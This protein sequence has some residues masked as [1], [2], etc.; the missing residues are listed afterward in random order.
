MIEGNRR[1]WKGNEDLRRDRRI[2]GSSGVLG[3]ALGPLNISYATRVNAP[4][5]FNIPISPQIPAQCY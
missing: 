3:E 5:H 1:L 2:M 4:P